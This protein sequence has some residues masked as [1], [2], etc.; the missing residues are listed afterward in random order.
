MEEGHDIYL[1]PTDINGHG[2][3]IASIIAGN[4]TV[5][6]SIL[7]FEKNVTKGTLKFVSYLEET[8]NEFL[9]VNVSWSSNNNI[10]V[11]IYDLAEEKI[12][13]SSETCSNG[14][15]VWN[16]RIYNSAREY[17]IFYVANEEGENVVEVRGELSFP[18]LNTFK[19][20]V[21][22]ANIVVLKVLDDQGYGNVT[23]LL[24][25]LDYLLTI[26]EEYNIKIVN[27]SLGFSERIVAVDDAVTA[28]VEEGIFPVVAAGNGGTSGEVYS[29]GSNDY[30]LTVGAVNER[31]EVAY[32]SSQGCDCPTRQIK[33]D[34]L[35]PGGSFGMA[36]R[37]I[38]VAK[39]GTYNEVK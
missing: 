12:R 30:A 1:S 36:F 2:T 37:P 23:T 7:K 34:V 17:L 33:P 29:P 28:I 22:G 5:N 35:A 3:A 21:P 9:T 11:G 19:G 10:S 13:Y 39:S 27:L 6:N 32:Y 24:E 31:A 16:R 15:F 18:T 25:A 20:V 38:I 14:S 8:N 4:C 26:K